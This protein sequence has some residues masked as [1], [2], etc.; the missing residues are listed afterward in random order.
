MLYPNGPSDKAGLMIGDKILTVND[1]PLHKKITNIDSVKKYIR[2]ERGS[3]ADLQILRGNK[4]QTLLLQEVQ[5]LF[6]LLMLLI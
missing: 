4:T 5:F 1:Y 2:G 6:L 3:K